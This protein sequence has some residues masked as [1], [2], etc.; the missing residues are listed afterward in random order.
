M[1]NRVKLEAQHT[2]DEYV[3]ESPKIEKVIELQD[4]NSPVTTTA[5]STNKD[6]EYITGVKL[7]MVMAVV[8]L[9]VFIMLL[10]SS[11]VAT[12]G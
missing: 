7:F 4:A 5:A 8:T 12:V 11:I 9:V 10:D 6:W 3:V 2:R 1:E